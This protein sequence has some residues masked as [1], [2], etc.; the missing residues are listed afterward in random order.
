MRRPLHY[1]RVLCDVPCRYSTRVQ[2]TRIYVMA[3]LYCIDHVQYE[4]S[5]YTEMYTISL[6][7]IACIQFSDFEQVRFSVY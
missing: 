6:L 3:G 7:L 4:P 5:L 2:Y 1:D